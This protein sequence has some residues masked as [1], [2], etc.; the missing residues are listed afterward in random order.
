M[1]SSPSSPRGWLRWAARTLEAQASPFS[2]RFDRAPRGDFRL[3]DSRETALSVKILLER[4]S[5]KCTSNGVGFD[6]LRRFYVEEAGW[7]AFTDFEQRVIAKT[8]RAFAKA[9]RAEG[10]LPRGG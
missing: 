2:P 6:L 5:A 3:R 10:F 8:A 7:G 9:L 1:R 4:A